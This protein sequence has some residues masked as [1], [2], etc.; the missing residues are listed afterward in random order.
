[1]ASQLNG[2]DAVGRLADHDERAVRAQ[3]V[4]EGSPRERVG[5]DNQDPHAIR[6]VLHFTHHVVAK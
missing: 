6:A 5:V 4:R 3:R 2:L 1:V